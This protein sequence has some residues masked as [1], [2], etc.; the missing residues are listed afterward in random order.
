[1]VDE[2]LEIICLME[3][4]L[5]PAFF[6]IQP[7][8]NCT[9]PT[10]SRFGRA[11]ALQVDVLYRTIYESHERVGAANGTPRGIH[12]FEYLLFEGMHYLTEYTSRLSPTAPQ[13]WKIDPRVQSSSLSKAHRIRRLDKDPNGRIFP[14]QAHAFVLRNDPC[15]AK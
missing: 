2:A 12:G 4:N 3:Q 6:D 11:S 13:L 1:M 8:Q 14:E 9:P 15:M 10:W 7:H 5:P